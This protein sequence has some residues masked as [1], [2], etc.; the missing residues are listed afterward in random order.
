M[1][2]YLKRGNP[3][4]AEDIKELIEL[5][6]P[7]P[8]GE[9][10]RN[11]TYRKIPD[12]YEQVHITDPNTINQVFNDNNLN[13]NLNVTDVYLRAEYSWYNP[14]EPVSITI[15]RAT[16]AGIQRHLL[17]MATAQPNPQAI[18]R[19][20]HWATHPESIDF[21]QVY[22][23]ENA[24]QDLL[25]KLMTVDTPMETRRDIFK[26]EESGYEL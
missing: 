8:D 19:Q 13:L 1:L 17:K 16:P 12:Y 15:E 25:R 9:P 2:R 26:V 20:M 5:A 4:Q 14:Q 11:G 23:G 6:K 7:T 10:S 18:P 21:F 24:P 3:Q 22:F